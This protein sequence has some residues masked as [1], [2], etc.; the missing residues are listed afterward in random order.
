MKSGYSKKGFTLIEIMLAMALFSI[1]LVAISSFF[2]FGLSTFG[3]GSRQY[4]V[5]AE[6]R[7][8][9]DYVTQE[10]RYATNASL[11]NTI[12]PAAI[13]DTD[14]NDYF[15]IENGSLV[16]SSYNNGNPRIRK[17][18]GKGIKDA[19][20]FSATS[21]GKHQTISASIF[22]EN[23]KQDYEL[24]S[25]IAL[26]NINISK[27]YMANTTSAKAIKFLK[28]TKLKPVTSPTGPPVTSPPPSGSP[29]PTPT[30]DPSVVT[31]SVTIEFSDDKDYMVYLGSQYKKV[32]K[33]G[34]KYLCVI[35]SVIGNQSYELRIEQN[36]G[37]IYSEI[38]K[39]P[40]F[41]VGNEDLIRK[42]AEIPAP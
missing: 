15:Y 42:V 17:E 28:D 10:M 19:S 1:I 12:D 37:G 21:D 4:D 26:P 22:A 33:I 5:Q 39:D 6:V 11:L 23:E 14:S 20:Y 40:A 31:V 36:I 2:D 27:S 8:A 9:V 7:L 13:S 16:F 29:T 41:Y 18:F 38:K 32:E 35:A 25:E 24:K 30:I 3:V 34:S